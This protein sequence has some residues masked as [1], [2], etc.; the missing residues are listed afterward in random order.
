MT[1]NLSILPRVDKIIVM[2]NWTIEFIGSYVEYNDFYSK[3]SNLR[4]TVKSINKEEEAG[5]IE[6]FIKITSNK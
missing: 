4:E 3:D 1:N 5:I 6:A 2:N